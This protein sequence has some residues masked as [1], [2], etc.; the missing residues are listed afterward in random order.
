[1]RLLT[2]PNLDNQAFVDIIADALAKLPHI[3][4]QWTDYNAHDPGI[5]MIE[6]FAW[7]KQYQ[8]YHLNLL[9]DRNIRSFLKLL[10]I[11]LMGAQQAAAF[12]EPALNEERLLPAGSHVYTGGGE[13]LELVK[14][15]MVGDVLISKIYLIRGES[16]IDVTGLLTQQ[17]MPVTLNKDETL[18]IGF[19]RVSKGSFSLWFSLYDAYPIPRNAPGE[20]FAY[21]PREIS[22]SFPG[23]DA[24]EGCV[25]TDCTNRLAFD[26]EMVFKTPDDWAKT[27]AKMG[28]NKAFW[29]SLTLNGIGCEE[30]L[31]LSGVFQSPLQ[32]E[33]TQTLSEEHMLSLPA[34]RENSVKLCSRLASIGVTNVLAR[35]EGGWY[36]V[37]NV[38][39]TFE[40]N[41][42]CKVCILSLPPLELL[43]DNAPNI[44]VSFTE[45][46]YVPHMKRSFSGMPGM[47]LPLYGGEGTVARISLLCREKLPDGRE[48]YQEWRMADTLDGAGAKERVFAY[49]DA[50]ECLCFGDNNNGALPLKGGDAVWIT[51]LAMTKGGDGVLLNNDTLFF[52][53]LCNQDEDEIPHG[54]IINVTAGRGKETVAQ[55]QERLNTLLLKP[56]RAVTASDYEEIA[57]RTP[58]LRVMAAKALPLYNGS[59]L[60]QAEAVVSIVVLPYSQSIRPMPEVG[61]L[62]VVQAYMDKFRPICTELIVLAPVYAPLTITA[63]VIATGN[64]AEVYEQVTTALHAYFEPGKYIHRV[65]EPVLLSSIMECIGSSKDILAVRNATIGVRGVQYSRNRRGDVVLPKHAIPYLDTLELRA[66]LQSI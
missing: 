42:G 58:G 1:M 66:G 47:Q 46:T 9:T 44:R 22:V 64:S 21:T 50:L 3:N 31:A 37:E 45:E 26:G 7:Y 38:A 27:D 8:Q 14:S 36:A 20:D 2:E 33:Q 24:H 4:P 55:A 53:D 10:G 60:G 29:L 41:N 35:D 49:D 62:S 48:R 25:I 18:Y 17:A 32:L 6:L 56:C 61:F 12:A 54:H 5:T 51:A 43:E 57:K 23:W 52:A 19:E 13:R 30:P 40:E 11:R 15:A 16:R 63:E 59:S 65:G 28:L 34:A 39:R